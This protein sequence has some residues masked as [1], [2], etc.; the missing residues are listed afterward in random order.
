MSNVSVL[1]NLLK[2]DITEFDDLHFTPSTI[3][4]QS[5][6]QH[7]SFRYG[8]DLLIPEVM[9]DEEET[10]FIPDLLPLKRKFSFVF[11][12]QELSKTIKVTEKKMLDFSGDLYLYINYLKFSC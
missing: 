7:E 10:E 9:L 1:I 12:D 4:A 5:N 11:L 2:L 6:F 3:I 8:R